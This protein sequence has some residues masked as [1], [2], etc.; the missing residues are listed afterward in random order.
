VVGREADD[1]GD[2][3]HLGR[4]DVEQLEVVRGRQRGLLVKF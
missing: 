4:L 3:D 1:D 2:G